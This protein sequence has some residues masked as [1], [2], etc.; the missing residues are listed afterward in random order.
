M[1]RAKRTGRAEARRRYRAEVVAREADA[2]ETT[3]TTP[4]AESTRRPA[5]RGSVGTTAP[6]A[7]PG[8]LDGLRTAMQPANVRADVVSAPSVLR[9]NRLLW[10]PF[11]IVA[12]SGAVALVP[13][14]LDYNIPQ[15]LA[16]TFVFPPPLIAPFVAGLLAPRAAWFFGFLAALLGA[17]FFAIVVATTPVPGATFTP[18]VRLQYIGY[19]F[20][21]SIFGALVGAFAGF[22]R[23]FLRTT[24]PARQ[25]DRARRATARPRR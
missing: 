17:V 10:V 15:L 20:V 3:E 11:L 1:A 14:A 18:E 4:R 16:T 7:R 23:R 21:S 13:G 9:S 8:F 2:A 24:G 6:S 19:A 25:S 5:D 12:V 22:Y